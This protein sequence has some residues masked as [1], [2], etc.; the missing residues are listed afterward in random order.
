M[1]IEGA[2]QVIAGKLTKSENL[3][4]LNEL[5]DL[6]KRVLARLSEQKEERLAGLKA[7]HEAARAKARAWLEKCRAMR[8]DL[9]SFESQLNALKMSASESRANFA[10]VRESAPRPEDYPNDQEIQEWQARMAEAET[11]MVAEEERARVAE[12]DRQQMA[13]NLIEAL[14]NFQAIE[15]QE[16]VLRFQ[17][18]GQPYQNSLGIVIEPEA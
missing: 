5:L 15:Q 12:L 17:L 1:T 7:E 8:N 10:A 6:Q 18:L 11:I 13:R 2:F 4:L 16:A 9:N 3:D 14:K